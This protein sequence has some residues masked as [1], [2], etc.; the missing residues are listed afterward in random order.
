MGRDFLTFFHSRWQKVETFV[1]ELPDTLPPSPSS[2]HTAST[3]PI[4]QSHRVFLTK[5]TPL[6]TGNRSDHMAQAGIRHQR[7]PR[8]LP[9][10]RSDQSTI[11]FFHRS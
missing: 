8:Y 3:E 1:E 6:L 7:I 5:A 9:E 4:F 10:V 11:T 2:P